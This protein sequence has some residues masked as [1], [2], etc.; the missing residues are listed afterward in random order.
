MSHQAGVGKPA[1]QSEIRS[2]ASE[3]SAITRRNT[4]NGLLFVLPNFIGFAI[5]VLIPVITMFYTAF[6]KWNALGKARFNGLTNWI[7]LLHDDT[8][9]TAFFN[10]LYYACVHIPLTLVIAFALALLL[11]SKIKGRAFFRTI[12]FF[13]YITAVVAIA[14]VWNMLFEPRAGII[15]QFLKMFTG[16]T[17]GWLT[18]P[19]WAMLAVIIVATWRET[20]YFMILLLAGLQTIPAELY[21]AAK[22]DGAN[23]WQRFWKVTVPQMRPTLF[24][25]IVTLTLTSLK[26]LDLTL[27][28]TNGGP[29]IS[30][31]VLA[32]YVYR[33]AFE[34]SDFGYSSTISLVLFLL[35]LVVTII[36]FRYNRSK[37]D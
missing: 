37:E 10:T 33:T 5:F 6:T 23:A 3:H 4:M 7:R 1:G 31:L 34:R 9:K 8:F 35:C 13:P 17:P 12:A 30:T 20:G 22:V 26:V 28:M 27:V 25:V 21:E 14:Q 36:Q 18:D 32:Q 24:F 19:K 15:N 11:N 16:S 2:H 29:G